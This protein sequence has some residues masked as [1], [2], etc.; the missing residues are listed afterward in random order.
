VPQCSVLGPLLYVLYTYGLGNILRRYNLDYNLYADDTQL[1]IS[2]CPKTAGEFELT[3]SKIES[4]V[5]E[6]R[7]WMTANFLKLNE[8]KI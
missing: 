3:V 4:C 2:F 8:D 6:I 1:Y 5:E 7:T